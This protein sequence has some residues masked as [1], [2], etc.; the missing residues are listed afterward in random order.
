MIMSNNKTIKS[1]AAYKVLHRFDFV[2]RM[3]IFFIDD[4]FVHNAE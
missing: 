3:E 4:G 1:K 2:W